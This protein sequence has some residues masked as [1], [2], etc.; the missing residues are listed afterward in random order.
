MWVSVG[1]VVEANMAS[2]D[3]KTKSSPAM[4]GEEKRTKYDLWNERLDI[5]G[6]ATIAAVT[7]K[8]LVDIA[9]S[10]NQMNNF[11]ILAYNKP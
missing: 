1:V 4:T 6:S 11:G 10:L 3:T 7:A 9:R 8:A 5:G 2:E